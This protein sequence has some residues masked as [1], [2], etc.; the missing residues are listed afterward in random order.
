MSDELDS[1]RI[2]LN[3]RGLGAELKKDLSGKVLHHRD[4]FYNFFIGRY[5][6]GLATLFFYNLPE[7]FEK[8]RLEIMLRSGQAVAYGKNRLGKMVV[9]GYIQDFYDLSN[10]V[11]GTYINRQ[12]YT[13]KDI[14]YTIPAALIPNRESLREITVNDAAETGNFVVFHNK[15]IN[16]TNDFKI[17]RHYAEELAEIVAS[18]FSLIMQAKMMT[19]ITSE[20]GDETANQM[21]SALYNGDPFVTVSKMFDVEDNIIRIDNPSLSTN[22]EALKTEYQNKIAELNSL[23]GINVLAVDKESGVTGQEANGNLGFVTV[24]AN[25]WL[26]SRQ[27]TLNLLN[28]RYG[29]DYKVTFDANAVGILPGA[30]ASTRGQDNGS[31]SDENDNNAGRNNQNGSTAQG[32]K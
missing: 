16:F 7:P 14:Q 10:G 9:L 27:Y 25:I 24:N 12:P 30:G 8:E 1:Y 21:V 2:P 26:E 3:N 5:M 20:V 31:D 22:L 32:N 6:E 17:I 11:E 13:G 19:V 23:F 4:D 15:S 18:R 29:A 28:K